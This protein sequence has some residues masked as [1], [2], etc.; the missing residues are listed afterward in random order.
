MMEDLDLVKLEQR[1]S[2]AINGYSADVTINCYVYGKDV[3]ALIR[4]IKT[5]EKTMEE[6]NA[7]GV[8]LEKRLRESP[9]ASVAEPK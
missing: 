7:A 2:K 8:A 5:L 6:M 3:L 9:V 1:A 4:R